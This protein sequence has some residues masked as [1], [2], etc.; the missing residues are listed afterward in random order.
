LELQAKVVAE[1]DGLG[2]QWL[3]SFADLEEKLPYLD[4]VLKESLRL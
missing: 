3:A 4:A 1:V 2:Q